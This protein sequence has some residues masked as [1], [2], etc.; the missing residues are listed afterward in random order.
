M[1][2]HVLR[3]VLELPQET[4]EFLLLSAADPAGDTG[5]VSRAAAVLGLP[6][7]APRPRS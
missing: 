7:D 6:E 5:V 1:E 4:Q 2:E 3:Q